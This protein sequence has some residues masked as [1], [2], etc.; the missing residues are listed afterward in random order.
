MFSFI[1]E[2]DVDDD[3]DDSGGGGGERKIYRHTDRLHK[4]TTKTNKVA[5]TNEQEETEN[6]G[7]KK[8]E[9]IPQLLLEREKKMIHN[10]VAD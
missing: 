6:D 4:K 2:F 5:F 9:N 10:Y 7:R 3:D 1:K 8:I